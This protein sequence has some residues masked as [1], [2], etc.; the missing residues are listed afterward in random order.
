MSTRLRRRIDE[1]NEIES[2]LSTIRVRLSGVPLAYR[3]D[4]A[5]ELRDIADSLVP[6]PP[7]TPLSPG[8]SHEERQEGEPP[9]SPATSDAI[10]PGTVVDRMRQFFRSRA[11]KPASIQE[12]AEGTA[13]A[14]ETVKSIL[15]KRNRGRFQ[16]VGEA[17]PGNPTSWK[18]T[19][20][21]ELVGTDALAVAEEKPD[22]MQ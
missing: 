2:F 6:T 14:F 13:A 18:M 20:L 5:A 10:A 7:L 9:E 19:D 15:Y 4:V 22:V 11:N 12:I 3:D 16:Q 21:L 8:G 17:S 1:L